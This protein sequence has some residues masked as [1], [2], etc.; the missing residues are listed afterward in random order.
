MTN[1]QKPNWKAAF[2]CK[3]PSCGT[4]GIFHQFI[5]VKP[6]CP[7][8]GVDFTQFE[9]ADGPA[10][11]AITIVGILIGMAAG[12]VEIVKEPPI[13][14]HF[15]LWLPLVFILSAIVIRITKT[16]MIAH[17]LDLKTRKPH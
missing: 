17:Q 5:K 6:S 11:F 2:L 10:F 15:A 3:C 4:S 7:K 9:T 13:W 16:L 1:T 12:I 8:C 14:V